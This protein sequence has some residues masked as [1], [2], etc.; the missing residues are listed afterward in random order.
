MH[1]KHNSIHRKI[2]KHKRMNEGEKETARGIEQGRETKKAKKK[3]K[4][5]Q[6]IDNHE[7]ASQHT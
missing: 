3:K 6:T 2:T 5:N 7:Q 4:C 1:W